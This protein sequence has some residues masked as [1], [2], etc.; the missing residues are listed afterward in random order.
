L[1]CRIVFDLAYECFVLA[2]HAHQQ[3]F[4]VCRSNFRLMLVCYRLDMV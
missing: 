4:D 3:F 2:V 1:R